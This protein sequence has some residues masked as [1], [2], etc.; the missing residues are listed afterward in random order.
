MYSKKGFTLAELLIVVVILG[1]LGAIALPRYGPQ[2]EKAIVGEAVGMLSAIRAG[3]LA[4][5]LENGT[6]AF[7][8]L[9]D[10]GRTEDGWPEIGIANP[11]AAGRFDYSVDAGNGWAE[12]VR[13][14]STTY[15]AANNDD[16][17]RID[18]EDGTWGGSADDHPYTPK[19]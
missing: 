6:G 17:I 11:N 7:L 1:V 13:V 18:L 9:P 8:A 5:R 15:S 19:N 3:E 2:R 4:W 12:A 10:A 16:T 14:G